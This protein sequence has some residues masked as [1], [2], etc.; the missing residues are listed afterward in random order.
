MGLMGVSASVSGFNAKVSASEPSR[1]S[2]QPAGIF[3]EDA[4]V[5]LGCGGGEEFRQHLKPTD[6]PRT[7][8]GVQDGAMANSLLDLLR[9]D[10]WDED[11]ILAQ[12]RRARTLTTQR[13]ARQDKERSRG[14][15]IR[16]NDN[17]TGN[18]LSLGET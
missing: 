14:S 13:Q 7:L 5:R 3:H 6:K 4:G 8:C 2:A 16:P 12:L 10:R 17:L 15:R 11:R 1:R 9:A 18:Q